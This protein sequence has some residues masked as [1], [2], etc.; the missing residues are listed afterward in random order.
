M[1]GRHHIATEF[2]SAL[3]TGDKNRL[4]AV[5]DRAALIASYGV[6]F[7][8]EHVLVSADNVALG[9]HNTARRGHRVLDEHLAT[10]CRIGD[11]RIVEIEIFLSD[12]PG[13]N[14][15]FGA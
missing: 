13:M 14:A 9:L 2:H 11:G 5:L 7:A 4:R 8:L 10:V 12:E 3:T 15:F 1:D 6:D